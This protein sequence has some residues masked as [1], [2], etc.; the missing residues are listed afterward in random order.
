MNK[1]KLQK[2]IEMALFLFGVAIF[3]FIVY[4]LIL[5]GGAILKSIF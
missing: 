1:E 3:G 4:H 2:Y 5:F